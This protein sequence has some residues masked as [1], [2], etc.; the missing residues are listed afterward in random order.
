MRRRLSRAWSDHVFELFFVIRCDAAGPHYVYLL[1][2]VANPAKAYVGYSD[3]Q[4]HRLDQHN[5]LFAGGA[6]PTESH[7]P[8]E[9]VCVVSGFTSMKEALAFELAWQQPSLPAMRQAPMMYRKGLRDWHHLYSMLRRRARCAKKLTTA[10][11][12]DQVARKLR[13][14]SIMLTIPGW[15]W[16][17]PPGD[18]ILPV[19]R[20]KYVRF[21]KKMDQDAALACGREHKDLFEWPTPMSLIMSK[22]RSIPSTAESVVIDLTS[23]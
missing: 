1:R 18:D 3:D 21:E 22:T 9:I 5:G 23:D 19:Y 12:L 14:L 15:G 11:G 4:F 2:S 7:R 16:F 13:I 17:G 10:A 6:S 8:W 20:K